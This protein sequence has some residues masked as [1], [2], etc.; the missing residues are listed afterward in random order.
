MKK[1]ILYLAAILIC[2]SIIT[3]GTLAYY[4]ASNTAR[5]VITSGGVEINVVEQQLVNGTLQPYPSQ[6][7]PVMPATTVSKIV[8][9]QSMEQAAW[10]RANYTI[11]VYDAEGKEM[12]ILADKLENV[13]V[14]VPDAINWTQKDGWWYYNTAIKSGETTKPLFE[15]VAFSGPD[16]DNNYQLCTV[17]IDVNAQAVQ[18]A[19]NGSAVMEAQGWPET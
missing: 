10:I 11:T 3:S 6:P 8:S 1:K 14:I 4:T 19:N 5:N 16:M 9:V 15:Q 2:L 7:I 18:Q 12:E 17:V 13:I